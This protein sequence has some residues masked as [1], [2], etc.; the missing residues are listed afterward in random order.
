MLCW[1]PFV[2]LHLRLFLYHTE[3]LGTLIWVVIEYQRYNKSDVLK[4]LVKCEKVWQLSN[5]FL[6]HYVDSQLSRLDNRSK[7]GFCESKILWSWSILNWRKIDSSRKFYPFR[8]G[9]KTVN[10]LHYWLPHF[11]YSNFFTAVWETLWHVATS[12]WL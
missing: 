3:H 9:K 8:G 4:I 11:L 10:H 12:F 2:C 7:I 1:N 5:W 6:G